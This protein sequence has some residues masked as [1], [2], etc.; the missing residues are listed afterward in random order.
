MVAFGFFSAGAEALWVCTAIGKKPGPKSQKDRERTS[1]DQRIDEAVSYSRRF[2]RKQRNDG[3]GNEEHRR[4]AGRLA[5]GKQEKRFIAG[6]PRPPIP[7]YHVEN[8]HPVFCSEKG[9]RQ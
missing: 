9:T 4:H 3:R 8:G 2:D 1:Y 6:Q 5:A 7:G